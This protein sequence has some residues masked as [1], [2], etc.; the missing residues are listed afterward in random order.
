MSQNRHAVTETRGV[1]QGGKV[2]DTQ[3]IETMGRARMIMKMMEGCMTHWMD[4][5]IV[6]SR[7]IAKLSMDWVGWPMCTGVIVLMKMRVI[8]ARQVSVK[9]RKKNLRQDA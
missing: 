1:L 4:R 3:Q 8:L 5:V 7:K 6:D 9:S 2:S